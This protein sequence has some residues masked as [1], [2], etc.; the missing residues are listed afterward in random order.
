MWS[1]KCENTKTTL[2]EYKITSTKHMVH[3]N[4]VFKALWMKFESAKLVGEIV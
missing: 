3:R 1:P 4:G 2:N